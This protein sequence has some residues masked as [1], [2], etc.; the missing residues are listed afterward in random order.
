M[1]DVIQKTYFVREAQAEEFGVKKSL[2]ERSFL[3]IVGSVFD[4]SHDFVN[5]AAKEH[6]LYV[7]AAKLRDVA[8]ASDPVLPHA[9]DSGEGILIPAEIIERARE[10]VRAFVILQPFG[11]IPNHVVGRGI[12]ARIK[13]M[14]PD[15]QLLPLDY[16]PD[17]SFTNVENRLQM[18]VMNIRSAMAT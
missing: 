3:K 1:S 11:C 17:V 14:F 7:P 18:L 12:A 13:K 15:I 16:D 2:A 10:G 6:P 9:Y 5:A 8:K 4:M